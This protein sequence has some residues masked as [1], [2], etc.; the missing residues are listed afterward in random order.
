MI[1]LIYKS[2]IRHDNDIISNYNQRIINFK[3]HN[4]ISD[5]EYKFLLKYNNKNKLYTYKYMNVKIDF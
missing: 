2:F 3:K 1:F 5:D 4:L